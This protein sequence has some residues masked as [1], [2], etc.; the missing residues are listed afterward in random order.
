MREPMKI[1]E[2]TPDGQIHYSVPTIDKKNINNNN[3]YTNNQTKLMN[4]K[5]TNSKV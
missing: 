2:Q 5:M 4:N 3:K 1:S